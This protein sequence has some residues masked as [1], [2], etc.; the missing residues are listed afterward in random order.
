MVTID[1]HSA[2]LD[3]LAQLL[4]KQNTLK[5]RIEDLCCI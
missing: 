3:L 1:N 2:Y 5:I 4:T